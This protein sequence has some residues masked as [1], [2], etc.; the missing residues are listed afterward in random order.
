MSSRGPLK[1]TEHTLHF[2]IIKKETWK[3][4]L[5]C[6][7]ARKTSTSR[8]IWIPKSVGKLDESVLEIVVSEWF[9]E[10]NDLWDWSI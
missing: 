2:A 9:C 7:N 6:F 3:A 1:S 5:V 4:W 8:E 10:L